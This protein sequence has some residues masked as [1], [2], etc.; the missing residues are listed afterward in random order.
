MVR[1][2]E[3]W[4]EGY[5]A[6]GERGTAKMIGKGVGTTFDEAVKDYMNKNPTHGIKE[7]VRGGYISEEYYQKRRSN[8]NIWACNLFDNESDARKSFG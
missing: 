1:E 6:T 8:W 5:A 7:N 3:I 4:T 2:F